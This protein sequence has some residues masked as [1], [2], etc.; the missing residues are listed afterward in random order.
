MTVIG[1][2]S[3]TDMQDIAV[4][5]ITMFFTTH[6]IVP[7]PS[8]SS[9]ASYCFSSNLHSISSFSWV[10]WLQISID[11]LITG[12][13]NTKRCAI[14]C[15]VGFPGD[16]EVKASA[17]NGGDPGSIPGLGRSPGERNVSP[18]Q[19]SCL[20]NPMEGGAWQATVHGVTKNW[21]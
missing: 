18:L 20:E 8:T 16:S 15:L 9:S 5:F 13:G 11:T 2:V 6:P 19:Y 4:I 14:E 3:V 17:C 10:G 21:T 12:Q 1:L 7:S